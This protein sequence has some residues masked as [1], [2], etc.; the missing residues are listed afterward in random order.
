MKRALAAPVGGIRGERDR[1]RP[2]H[3]ERGITRRHSDQAHRHRQVERSIDREL[4]PLV[5]WETSAGDSTVWVHRTVLGVSKRK[6]VQ[7]A[8]STSAQAVL[9]QL[10]LLPAP[11]ISRRSRRRKKSSTS[12]ASRAATA[13]PREGE[14]VAQVHNVTVETSGCAARIY[15]PDPR[16]PVPGIIVHFHGG[17]WLTGSIEMSDDACRFLANRSGCVVMSAAYRFAPEHPFPAAV[18]RRVR[19]LSVGRDTRRRLRRGRHPCRRDRH[20]RGR[21]PRRSDV[22]AR[23]RGQVGPQPAFQVLVYPPLDATFR[24]QSFVDNATGYY[25]TADQ[26]R[27]FW[28]QYAGQTPR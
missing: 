2:E 3:P 20:Q 10:A 6:E 18:G 12:S 27:W 23:R 7:M 8:L 9:E 11:P 28:S 22:P 21:N 5:H 16:S 4:D 14:A 15:V 24:S 17:G 1:V 19:G 13:V 25:L 26:M